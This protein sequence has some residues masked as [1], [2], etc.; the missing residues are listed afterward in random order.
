MNLLSLFSSFMP[1]LALSGLLHPIHVSVT[2][3]EYDETDQAL[4]VMI[5]VFMDDLELSLRESFDQPHLDVLQPGSRANLDN[6]VKDY[7]FQHFKIAL[8][9]KPQTPRYLGHER[10]AE[11]FIFYVEVPHVQKWKTIT[12]HN[13]IIMATYD[14][15]S[16]IIHVYVNDDVKSLRLTKRTPADNLTFP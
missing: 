1:V 6:L 11:A 13:D 7:L 4:E 3:I 8:D 12:I 16:N 15:Q 10:E 9:G 14:D 5:R 2:E